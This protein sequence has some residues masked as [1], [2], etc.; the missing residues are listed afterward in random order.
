MRVGGAIEGKFA[1]DSRGRIASATRRVD[2]R[3]G[4]AIQRRGIVTGRDP[5][6]VRSERQRVVRNAWTTRARVTTTDD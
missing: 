1:R 4:C 6:V 3:E 2:A 5:A